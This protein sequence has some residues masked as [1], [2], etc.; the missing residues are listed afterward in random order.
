MRRTVVIL[1]LALTVGMVMGMIQNHILNAQPPLAG[2]VLPPDGV[3]RFS[4]PLGREADITEVLATRERTGDAFGLLRQTIAPKSGPPAHIHRGEDEFFYIVSG[5]FNFKLGDRLMLA[6]A[7]S[8][9][10]VPRDMVHTFQNIG[11][12]PGVLLAGVT[13]AGFEKFF[14]E[15]AGVD[16]QTLK[17]LMQKHGMEVVGPPLQ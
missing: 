4:G 3:L 16:A 11:A 15:R 6:P 8:I 5:Q 9:V 1:A 14:E 10:F 17:A 12:E 2:F 13:P 7:G